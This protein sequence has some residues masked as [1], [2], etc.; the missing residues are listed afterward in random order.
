MLHAQIFPYDPLKLL[1]HQ[2]HPGGSQCPQPLP[3]RPHLRR[4]ED[5][6]KSSR[7]AHTTRGC[8]PEEEN[9]RGGRG[10]GVR[11]Q[12]STIYN[13]GQDW[14]GHGSGRNFQE[15]SI[16]SPRGRPAAG[17]GSRTGQGHVVLK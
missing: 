4:H 17:P 10:L 3:R 9:Q 8:F 14:E 12:V 7:A 15:A 13:R 1:T 2:H 16:C 5:K 6:W 11:R